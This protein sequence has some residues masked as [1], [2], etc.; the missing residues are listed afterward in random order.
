MKIELTLQDWIF[1]ATALFTGIK[2]YFERNKLPKKYQ[3]ILD[4]IGIDNITNLI[5]K[6]DHF[7][8][9]NSNEKRILVVEE[10][11][12]FVKRECDMELPTSLANLLVEYV[13]NLL[14]KEDK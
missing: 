5:Q 10:L 9:L 6:I 7:A 11:K 13:F 4:R 2:W 3:K 12:T 14:K 1:I 8:D